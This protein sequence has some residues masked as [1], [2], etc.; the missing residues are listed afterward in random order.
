MK[1][2]EA[3]GDVNG[4]SSWYDSLLGLFETDGKMD[5]NKLFGALG[6]GTGVAGL[7]GIG[8]DFFEGGQ[9][10][11]TGYQ[12]SIP[13]YDAVR[14]RVAQDPNAPAGQG[15]RY[16]SDVQFVPKEQQATSSEVAPSNVSNTQ[17]FAKGGLAS[18]PQSKGYYLGGSTDGMADKVP[19]TIEGRE[20]A[21]LSDGE[22]VIPADVVSHLGNGNSEAGAKVLYD[23]MD[24]IRVARTGRKEQGKEINPN[25]MTPK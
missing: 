13:K 1:Y 7:L 11:P 24:R 19:A 21:R 6:A 17:Q 10:A 8:G 3:G 5:Y 4:E 9:S 12:G 23:M 2:Y 14:T 22:F 18:M 15:K 16:F 25:K 20:E